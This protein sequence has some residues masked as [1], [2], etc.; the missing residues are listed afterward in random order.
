V[1]EVR[2]INAISIV[3]LL[4]GISFGIYS[5]LDSNINPVSKTANSQSTIISDSQILVGS[6]PLPPLKI[7]KAD[8]KIQS[9][10]IQ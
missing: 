9:V 10:E 7:T 1:K 8:G 4:S 2:V 3:A 6:N 5:I